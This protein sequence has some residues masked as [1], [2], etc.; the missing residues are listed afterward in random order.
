LN[1]GN[2]EKGEFFRIQ[3]CFQKLKMDKNKCPFSQKGG[4]LRKTTRK[5]SLLDHNGAISI[6]AV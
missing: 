1:I 2:G 3:K 5:I 6:I 4:V